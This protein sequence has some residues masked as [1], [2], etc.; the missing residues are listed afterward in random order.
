MVTLFLTKLNLGNPTIKFSS[1]TTNLG[2]TFGVVLGEVLQTI[3]I[4]DANDYAL[5]T[6]VLCTCYPMTSPDLPVHPG[7]ET[8]L[9]K[10][11]QNGVLKGLC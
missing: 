6:Y 7:K 10:V 11:V 4:L 9:P 3:S 5:S 2:S 1:A 8:P